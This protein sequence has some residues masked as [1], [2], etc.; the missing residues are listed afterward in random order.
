V[1][2]FYDWYVNNKIILIK[3]K[4]IRALAEVIWKITELYTDKEKDKEK[5]GFNNNIQWAKK[6]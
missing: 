5:K 3:I 1:K 6:W 4:T 2:N